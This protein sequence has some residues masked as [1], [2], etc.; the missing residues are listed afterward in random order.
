MFERM[1]VYL[2][3]RDQER[4][5]VKYEKLADFY[6]AQG[7]ILK[8]FCYYWTD[9]FNFHHYYNTLLDFFHDPHH[10]LKLSR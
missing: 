4:L 9:D 3:G 1:D 5:E 6:F 7:I 2:L 10:Y 8:L